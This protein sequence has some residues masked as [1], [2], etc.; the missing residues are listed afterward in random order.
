MSAVESTT[1]KGIPMRTIMLLGLA[2]ALAAMGCA[3]YAAKYD[4][5]AYGE[6]AV[7]SDPYGVERE[8]QGRPM[9]G[10]AVVRTSRS[11]VV[12]AAGD[13]DATVPTEGEPTPML[14]AVEPRKVI[15]SAH[16]QVGTAEPTKAVEK[17]KALAEQR[18]GYMQRMAGTTI[19]IRIPAER[20][21]ETMADLEQLGVV[22]NKAITAQDVTE[23]FI[24]LELRLKNNEVLLGKLHALLEKAK[25]VKQALAVE[26]EI[27]RV[28][29]EIERLTGRLNRMKDRIAM[30]TI[31]VEFIEVSA[32]PPGMQVQLPFWWLGELGLGNLLAF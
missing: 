17:T 14:S 18:G 24:D 9:A 16:M 30:A 4:T 20:F 6:G 32:V 11:G 26:K 21:D 25:D 3:T 10:T 1:G 31:T 28:Q 5:M 27:A 2:V 23:E 15:Y 29:T 8:R 7:A 19:V 22:V 13:V 12:P